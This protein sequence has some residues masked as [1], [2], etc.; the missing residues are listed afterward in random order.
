MVGASSISGLVSGLDWA[1]VISKLIAV[2]RRPINILDQRQTEYEN[3]LSAWQSLNTKL[4]SLKTQASQLNLNTAFN[5]FK[6]TLTSSSSTKPE[7]ILAVTT[8][9]DATPGVYSVEVSSLAAARKLSSQSFT[10]K[11]TTLGYSGDIVINGRAINIAT[12]DTLVDIQGKINNVNSGSNATKI[13]ASIVS[14]SSTDYRLILTSDDT[15]QNVF[16]I[17]DASAS[18]VLQS[19]GFTTSSVSINNPTSDGAKSNTFTSSTTDIRSLLGLSST[20]SSTTVQIG[21]NNVSINLDTDSLQTI[22]ATIDALAGISASVVTTTVNGQT[23]YQLDISGTTSFTDANNILETLGVLKGTNGQGNEVHAGS[24]ANTTDGSTPITATNT[25][26]QIFGAN[27]GTTDTI[28]IQGTKNDGTAITTTTYN[29]YSGGSYKSIGDLLTTIESLYGGASYVDAYISDGTDG[30][31]AGQAVIKD[32]TAGNSRMTLTLVAN[33]EGGG[34]LDFGDIT[35]RT[36]GYS[37]QVTAG[38]DAVFAVDGTTMTRTSNTITDVITGVTLDLKKAE[39]G[40]SITLNISRDLDAVKE[41]ISDF[42]ETYNGVIGYINE[43]YYYDEEKKTGGVLMDDGSLRSVQSDIQSI[44]RNTI[45]GLP[46]T[47]NALAFIG[48]KSDYNQGGKLAIDDTKLT[49]MLQ[50]DFMGVRRLF[51]AEATASNAQVSYVYHTENTKAGAFEIS[52]TQAATQASITGTTDLSGGLGGAETLTITDTASGRVANIGLTAGQSLTSIV[53]AINSKLATE[54]TEVLTGS[55][56]NT[57]TS[58][59]GGGAISSTTKWSEINT[60]GDSNDI[61]N[62]GT[63]SFSGTTRTGQGVSG[64]YT[65]TDK[66]TQTVAGLLSAIESAFNNEVYATIDTSGRLVLTD[67]YTGDS[68]ISL[69]LTENAGSLDFGTMSVT[70]QGRSAMSITASAS[71]NYLKITHNIYGDSNGFTISQTANYTGITNG[72]YAGVDVAGTINGETVTGS[73][74]ILTG[75]SDQPNIAGLSISYSGTS[76]GS[77]GNITLTFGVAEQLD[78]RLKFITDPIDGYVTTRMDGL[79]DNIDYLQDRMDEME[80][81][82]EG[83]TDTLYNQ[84]IAMES[85]LARMQSIS[86]WLSQQLGSLNNMWR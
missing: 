77:M 24:K 42:V 19:L 73:G 81:R 54:Y 39:A 69:S 18:N 51:A 50:S 63:I 78:N 58:A 30:N 14:Y 40:T 25:F 23:L 85:A 59:A 79:Q 47:L 9:T 83:R 84:Y 41:L 74:Q 21:S 4:L 48:I 11:T 70:T 86:N 32:L 64:T 15:G 6:N 2:E 34:T 76:T 72:S 67:K 8:S 80:K 12:T 46:T 20:L 10:S 43:Q 45:N 71:G 82:L 7:D 27:V 68:N 53:N 62:G 61:S 37:M 16:R 65:I 33:N 3:K 35:A 17:A 28:T 66:N 56:A 57:K 75:N 22:A 5:L 13:T 52:I 55:V 49:S 29:I 1:E 60:G 31:T 26:D 44:I 36:K 38:A